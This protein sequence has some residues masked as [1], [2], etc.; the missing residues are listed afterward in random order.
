MHGANR[1][2]CACGSPG[3]RLALVA[4]VFASLAALLVVGQADGASRAW[5]AYLAPTG[6]CKAAD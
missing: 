4:A 5:S 1:D 3:P 6:A 2:L